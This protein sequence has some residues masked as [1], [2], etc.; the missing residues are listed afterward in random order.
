MKPGRLRERKPT[1][2]TSGGATKL[3]PWSPDYKSYN[4]PERNAFFR[5]PPET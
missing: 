1:S 4:D 3:V 2:R 5:L